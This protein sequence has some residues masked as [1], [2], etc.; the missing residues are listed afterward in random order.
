MD[1][2]FQDTR[3]ADNMAKLHQHKNNDKYIKHELRK[4]ENDTSMQDKI[5]RHKQ[6]RLAAQKDTAERKL[7]V[8]LSKLNR[9]ER[10]KEKS[11][12]L[13]IME[14]KQYKK[15]KKEE[16]ALEKKVRDQKRRNA[17]TYRN[18]MNRSNQRY[19]DGFEML[20]M[21]RELLDMHALPEDISRIIKN[22]TKD[23]GWPNT[24]GQLTN[25]YFV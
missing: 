9:A 10:K 14:S 24:D 2:E 4:S 19:R 7:P 13:Q 3:R 21:Q 8:E 11:E 1:F 17:E 16:K 6:S 23:K 18:A 20:R 12:R 22:Q 5:Y 15:D 25:P